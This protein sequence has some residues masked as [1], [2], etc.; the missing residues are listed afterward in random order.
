MYSD[1]EMSCIGSDNEEVEVITHG[2]SPNQTPT[3]IS[4]EEAEV[5][6]SDQEYDDNYMAYVLALG[7]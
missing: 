1:N 3:D 6:E 4:S 5:D 7:H 2:V